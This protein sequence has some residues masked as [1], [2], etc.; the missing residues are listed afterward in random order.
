LGSVVQSLFGGSEQESSSTPQDMTPDQFAG[1]R[2]QLGSILSQI[3]GGTAQDAQGNPIEGGAAGGGVQQF[4]DLLAPARG[5]PN[6]A[7]VG[8][9]EQTLLN[10]LMGSGSGSRAYLDDVLS[11]EY[12]R[13][14]NPL[15][16]QY[17]QAAQR[18]TM[19]ALEDTLTR[20]LPGQFT[21]A[22]QNVNP[23]RSSPFDMAA[24]RAFEASAN[25]AGDIATEIGFQ[26]HEGERNRMQQAVQLDQQQVNQMMQNLQAQALPR[27]IEQHGMDAGMREYQT[28]VQTMLTLLQTLQT[29]TSP[30]VAQVASGSGSSQGGIIPGLLGT[31]GVGSLGAVVG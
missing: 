15:L 17:I 16:Q 18:P 23:G 31:G 30:N 13:R 20:S 8:A 29:F 1:L 28:R 2:T 9:N 11:G 25:T 3:M 7:A 26:A 19:Q 6:T 10:R 12:A 14:G 27:L 24:A 22:G 4:L 21:R 5:G